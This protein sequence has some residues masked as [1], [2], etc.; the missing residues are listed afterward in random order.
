MADISI[1]EAKIYILYLVRAVPGISF[2]MLEENSADSLYM[3]YFT[4][5]QAYDELT[6]GNLIDKHYEANGVTDALGGTETLTITNG[7]SA[8]LDE[9]LPTV[10]IPLL[11]HLELV[12]KKLTEQMNSK[13]SVTAELTRES[14]GR[15]KVTLFSDREGKAFRAAF[16]CDSE[17]EA[18]KLC[19]AWKNGEDKAV[20]AFFSALG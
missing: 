5:N 18:R 20:N 9:V 14:D 7:G 15:F 4:F 1:A 8:M 17:A 10:R 13:I 11:E 12:S 16:L 6:A 3:N 19:D 2:H